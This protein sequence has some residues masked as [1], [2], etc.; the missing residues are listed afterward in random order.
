MPESVLPVRVGMGGDLFTIDRLRLSVTRARGDGWLVRC[1][2]YWLVL[3]VRAGIRDA[4]H[5][6]MYAH[7]R[8]R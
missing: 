6:S 5:E 2:P 8:H 7:L 4:V 3:S 1:Y